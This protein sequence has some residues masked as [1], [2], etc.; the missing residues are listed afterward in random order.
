MGWARIRSSS[1]TYVAAGVY[2]AASS[3]RT[4]SDRLASLARYRNRGTNFGGSVLKRGTWIAIDTSKLLILNWLQRC[5]DPGLIRGLAVE[6]GDFRQYFD[7]KQRTIVNI[8]TILLR[9]W[10][11]KLRTVRD[12]TSCPDVVS[13]FRRTVTA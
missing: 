8:L 10:S 1:L 6:K 3:S 9:F 2:V 12:I 7:E 5:L 4:T 11:Q 13:S